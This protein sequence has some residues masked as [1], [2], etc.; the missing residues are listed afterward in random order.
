M[1]GRASRACKFGRSEVEA[2]AGIHPFRVCSAVR[3]C[4]IHVLMSTTVFAANFQRLQ[5]L[6]EKSTSTWHDPVLVVLTPRDQSV[7]GNLS[8]PASEDRTLYQGTLQ[9]L[10]KYSPTASAFSWTV[11]FRTLIYSNST[12]PSSNLFC[13]FDRSL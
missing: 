12:S 13:S 8:S 4:S 11:R 5:R 2:G 9:R 3:D 6:V 10:Q 7:R 1:S